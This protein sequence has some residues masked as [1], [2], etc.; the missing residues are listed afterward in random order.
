MERPL[1]PTCGAF[2]PTVEEAR[3][4]HRPKRKRPFI[5]GPMLAAPIVMSMK[6]AGKVWG[7][8]P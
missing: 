8:K 1:C 6:A 5:G 7:L 3:R 2:H 4:A